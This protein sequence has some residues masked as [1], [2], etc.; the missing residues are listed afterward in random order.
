MAV[1]VALWWRGSGGLN[2]G[3]ET[4][5]ASSAT[6]RWLLLPAPPPLE[7]WGNSFLPKSGAAIARDL[8][9]APSVLPRNLAEGFVEEDNEVM[10][11][12]P[13]VP[14]FDFARFSC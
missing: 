6:L 12:A 4:S 1:G 3:S 8:R 10:H 9:S 11:A 14:R 13:S 5:V 2:G 7:R